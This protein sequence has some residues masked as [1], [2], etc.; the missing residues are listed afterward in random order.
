MGP[1]RNGPLV[2]SDGHTQ[3][4]PV[5]EVCDLTVTYGATKAVDGVSLH[6]DRGEIFGLLGPNGAGKTSTLSAIEGLLKPR[7][8]TVVVDGIDVQQHRGRATARM[9]VQLQATS[10]HAQLTITQIARLYAGLYGME[11]SAGEISDSLHA[12]GL[13]KEATKLYKQLSGG[14]QQRLSLYV[15]VMH[16]PVLLLLD[17]PTSGLDPQSRRQLWSRIE[18]RRRPRRQHPAHHSLHGGSAGGL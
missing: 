8:G 7:S 17:E 16:E 9:G 12:I 11:Q 13:G 15:A 4:E 14:Q 3:A 1:I 5:L 2:S 10:F 6:I 18:E